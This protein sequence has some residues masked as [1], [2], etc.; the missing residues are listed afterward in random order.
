MYKIACP[1]QER[2]NSKLD[3][4]LLKILNLL[5]VV[6]RRN[7]CF[8]MLFIKKCILQGIIVITILLQRSTTE[9]QRPRIKRLD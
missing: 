3:R 8:R 2:K 9:A 1:T 5:R 7:S 6:P 4:P